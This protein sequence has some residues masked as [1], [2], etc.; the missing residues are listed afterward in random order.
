MPTDFNFLKVHVQRVPGTGRRRRSRATS[1]RRLPT[2]RRPSATTSFDLSISHIPPTARR[3]DGEHMVMNLDRDGEPIDPI[4]L[5]NDDHFE[6]WKEIR[7]P[8]KVAI[9][10]SPLG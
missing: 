9:T 10:P 5:S 4:R 2:S 7:K 6:F 8:L 1:H 3:Q